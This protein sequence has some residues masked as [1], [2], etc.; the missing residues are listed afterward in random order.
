MR[1]LITGANGFIGSH[2]CRYFYS[3]GHKV[4]GW[5]IHATKQTWDN[6]VV[7]LLNIDS[8]LEGLDTFLPDIIIHCAG[9]A[10]VGQSFKN[11]HNDFI[12]NV[13]VTHNLFFA[14][15]QSKVKNQIRLI[16]LS[17]AGV[18]GNP[19]ILPIS[20]DV[21]VNPLSPYAIHKIMCEDLC[22]Y[23]YQNYHMDIKILRIFSAYGEG[24]KKQI[25]WDMYN[26]VKNTGHLEMFGTGDESRDYIHI[27]DL[28]QAIYLVAI[29][30][31]QNEQ[32][33]N[34]ANGRETT[35]REVAEIFADAVGLERKKICFTGKIKEGNPINWC[36]DISKLQQLGYCK[37]VELSDGINRYVQWAGRYV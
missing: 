16:Y 22:K 35:I 25:F 31:N 1:V 36:A 8:I 17:S 19:T 5:D 9:A 11:P 3:I 26:K 4:M 24:L 33:Y 30:S 20:E 27:D 21:R 34:I 23:F 32:I 2:L 15:N 37:S 12:S 7:N 6:C 18:Y 28:V 10:D 14:L 13:T 29:K